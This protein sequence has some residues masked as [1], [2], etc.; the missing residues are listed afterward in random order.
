MQR[1]LVNLALFL[2]FLHAEL[3]WSQ[4]DVGF[5]RTQSG[6]LISNV[7]SDNVKLVE[8]S[9]VLQ[10]Q[11]RLSQPSVLSLPLVGLSSVIIQS[12][13]PVPL[14]RQN[15]HFYSV[16]LPASDDLTLT[17]NIDSQ[18]SRPY[19]LYLESIT[20][21]NQRITSHTIALFLFVGFA[22]GLAMYVGLLGRGIKQSGFYAYSAY[23][24][25][26]AAF[27]SLQEG[28]LNYFLPLGSWQNDIANQSLLAGC[29]VFFA[30]LFLARLL[31]LKLL[32][33]R[34][35]YLAIIG[36]AAAVMSLGI[37]IFFAPALS[38]KGLGLM[39][40]WTTL[41]VIFSLFVISGYAAVQR[42]HTANIVFCAL[43]IV[44]IAML[45]RVWLNDL[46]IFLTRYGLIVS[47]AI[48]S[49]LFAYAASEKV[50]HLEVE[51]AHAFLTASEDP[52]CRL[53]N[54][55]GW[56]MAVQRKIDRYR[57]RDGVFL[58]LFIDLNDFK[59]I[60][61]DRGHTFGD[62]VLQTFAK[63]LRHQT[64]EGDIVGRF[65]G[66]EFVVFAHAITHAH[67]KRIRQRYAQKLQQRDVWI[68]GQA[69]PLSAAVGNHVVEVEQANL[70]SMLQ[71]ADLN[72][73]QHKQELKATTS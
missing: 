40:A 8:G 53:L 25:F 52:L 57:D 26:V 61:D 60:N 44:F 21:F 19:L 38:T 14:E 35:L 13:S 11:C 32:I 7:Q 5:C 73:Y 1:A 6:G 48:E 46:S 17:V 31:D 59:S 28:L 49:F 30:T 12:P 27:F 24:F 4:A 23:L 58:L 33:N 3:A 55:R 2:C 16:L 47:T 54:R 15:S 20:E 50:K 18:R 22:I 42:I 10:L 45:F 43:A 66:D 68:D 29:V 34:H 41:A 39:M 64:R 62:K 56:E 65:G 51:K 63:I 70:A 69:L 9:N 72:M 37:L 36:A 71:S 67:A